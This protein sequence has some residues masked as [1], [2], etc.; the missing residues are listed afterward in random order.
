MTRR[1]QTELRARFDFRCGYCGVT[2]TDVGA[3]LHCDHFHPTS[4]GGAEDAS[5]WVYSCN[6]YNGFKGSY[7]PQNAADFALLHPL[8]DDLSIH[9]REGS[10]AR[11]GLSPR[12]HF[13]IELL[14]LNRAPLVAHRCKVT[15]DRELDERIRELEQQVEADAQLI[16]TLL[17][18]LNDI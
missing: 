2:E 9:L 12:G 16:G 13:H 4:R 15:V 14:H 1:E 10:G 7:W 17:E 6:A 11:V 8:R 18:Q 3:L 5:N